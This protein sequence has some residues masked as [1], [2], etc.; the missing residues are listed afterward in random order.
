MYQHILGS[1]MDQV[2]SGLSVDH[3]QAKQLA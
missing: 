2:N 1:F 3:F